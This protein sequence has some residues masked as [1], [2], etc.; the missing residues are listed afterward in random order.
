MDK[1][2]FI[3]WYNLFYNVRLTREVL[4]NLIFLQIL[5]AE[6]PAASITFYLMR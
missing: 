3:K 4:A 1:G 2:F 5:N 6:Y